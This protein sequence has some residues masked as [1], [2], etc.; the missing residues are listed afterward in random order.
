MSKHLVDTAIV[1]AGPY[2]LSLAAHLGHHGVDHRVIGRPMQF[3]RRH[4]PKGKMLKSDGFASSLSTP[5][6]QRVACRLLS[7]R[8]SGL[9]H[10]QGPPLGCA[11]AN[12]AK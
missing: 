1:G 6:G 11:W 5:P 9:P 7:H 12:S 2:A 10:P 4:M 8:G 3:W